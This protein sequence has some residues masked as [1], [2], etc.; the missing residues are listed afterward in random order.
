MRRVATH[1]FVP[2][3]IGA[4]TGW[5]GSLAQGAG[6]Q[7]VLF[8]D[9]RASSPEDGRG[10]EEA[11]FQLLGKILASRADPESAAGEPA[12]EPPG[13]EDAARVRGMEPSAEETYAMRF[14]EVVDPF[15]AEGRAP[16]WASTAERDLSDA[17]DGYL[18]AN[19]EDLVRL[20]SL[21]CRSSRCR[22]DIE[23]RSPRDA[24]RKQKDLLM[25]N[26]FGTGVGRCPFKSVGRQDGRQTLVFHC[27]ADL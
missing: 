1:V 12:S 21:E 17:F 8:R 23:W 14:G 22:A 4:I 26:V 7:R 2:A 9:D 5:L 16:D 24:E 13:P 18:A 15:L 25:R 20:G 11:R 3:L 10:R 19:G 6:D 27:P